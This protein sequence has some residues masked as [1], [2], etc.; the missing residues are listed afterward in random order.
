MPAAGKLLV[1]LFQTLAGLTV[2]AGVVF[3]AR[4]WTEKQA[5]KAMSLHVGSLV[6]KRAMVVSD[7]RAGRP[8]RIRPMDAWVAEG[9]R[10]VTGAESRTFPALSDQ[11]ISRGRV[12]RVTGGS[13]EGYLV[14]PI[15]RERSY[16]EI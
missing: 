9:D 5:R 10:T 11:L 15:E 8:G 13:P 4:Y 6:G 3:L 1:I 14:R 2:L 16:V 7:L 12:V